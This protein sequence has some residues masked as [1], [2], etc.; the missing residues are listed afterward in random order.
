MFK[1]MDQW[2]SLETISGFFVR[3]EGN[4]IL[5]KSSKLDFSLLD[6]PTIL[7]LCAKFTFYCGF[8]RKI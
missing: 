6:F 1:L 4:S 7:P 5:P 8:K 3:F 2:I